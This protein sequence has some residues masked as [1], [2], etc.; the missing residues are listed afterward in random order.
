MFMQRLKTKHSETENNPFWKVL[1]QKVK[2]NNMY[3]N[4]GR[5]I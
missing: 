3:K 2:N 4:G 5:L 1:R